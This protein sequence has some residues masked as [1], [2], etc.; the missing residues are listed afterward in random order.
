MGSLS[1]PR[2]HR[3]S[4]VCLLLRW[5]SS[6]AASWA[7]PGVGGSCGPAS[8]PCPSQAPRPPH[9]GALGFPRADRLPRRPTDARAGS[10]RRDPAGGR[11]PRPRSGRGGGGGG[12]GG[13]GGDRPGRSAA[14][15]D[16][17]VRGR[18]KSSARPVWDPRQEA[19][20][21]VRCLWVSCLNPSRLHIPVAHPRAWNPIGAQ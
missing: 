13:R 10:G 5:R 9:A 2:S 12:E 21:G 4:A 11:R 14:G 8:A 1:T 17:R 6:T 15:A 20:L 16:T 7:P 19:R 18:P 3:L